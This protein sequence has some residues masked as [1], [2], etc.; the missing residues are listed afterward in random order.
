MQH[1]HQTCVNLQTK[2]CHLIR[3][4]RERSQVWYSETNSSEK[5][6]LL[7]T[8]CC[9]H[10]SRLLALPCI[11]TTYGSSTRSFACQAWMAPKRPCKRHHST[12]L[13]ECG[14]GPHPCSQTQYVKHHVCFI[15]LFLIHLNQEMPKLFMCFLWASLNR[16]YSIGIICLQ[17]SLLWTYLCFCDIF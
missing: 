9:Q 2:F 10:W 17:P 14:A 16:K 4:I 15:S 7:P 8:S 12:Y 11:S 5:L 6:F 3:C 1:C 13:D